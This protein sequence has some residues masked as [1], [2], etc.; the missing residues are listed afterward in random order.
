MSQLFIVMLLFCLERNNIRAQW[1]RNAL[2]SNIGCQEFNESHSCDYSR[3]DDQEC[4]M[5]QETDRSVFIIA[6]I[7]PL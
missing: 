3:L 6:G 4:G 2:F 1:F 7:T 5:G